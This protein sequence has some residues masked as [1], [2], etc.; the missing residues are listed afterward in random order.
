MSVQEVCRVPGNQFL[1]VS[2]RYSCLGPWR[3][4]QR[5]SAQ[6]AL[7]SIPSSLI[8]ISGSLPA[9]TKGPS[10]G[11]DLNILLGQAKLSQAT[12]PKLKSIFTTLKRCE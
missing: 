10:L 6:V 5:G 12:L 11:T 2:F 3:T 8:P 4:S 1:F 7:R 9:A